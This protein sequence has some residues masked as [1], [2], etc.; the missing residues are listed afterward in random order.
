[1][2]T[3]S[4]NFFTL[5]NQWVN[6]IVQRY[7]SFIFFQVYWGII[8]MWHCEGLRSTVWW[9]CT[10]LQNDSHNKVSK[11]THHLT[12]F[13]QHYSSKNKKEIQYFIWSVD[14]NKKGFITHYFVTRTST[15]LFCSKE[16]WQYS[17]FMMLVRPNLFE[18]I[19]K[20]TNIEGWFVIK[21]IRRKEMTWIWNNSLGWS[22]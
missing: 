21:E 1:M 19:V 12:L 2:T 10:F 20:W 17:S 9:I 11:Y 14:F 4:M 6:N 3:S 15:V 5:R 7:S 18:M 13:P 8:N 22:V 16:V